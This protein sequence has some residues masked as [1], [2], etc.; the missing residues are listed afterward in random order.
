MRFLR[1]ITRSLILLLIALFSA[2]AAMRFAIHGREVRVPNLKGLSVLQAQEMANQAGLIVAVDDKFYS[3]YVPDGKIISQAP[4]ANS[5]VRRGW[6]VRVAE[7][8]GEQRVTIPDLLGQTERAATLNLRRRGLEVATVA[9]VP[10]TNASPDQVVA[11]VPLANAAEVSS[12]KVSI[13]LAEAP[14]SPEFVMPNFLGRQLADAKQKV[15]RAGLQIASVTAAATDPDASA[16]MLPV[17]SGLDTAR[18]SPKSGKIVSQS[19]APGA[20]VTPDTQIRFEIAQ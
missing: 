15:A 5:K 16:S 7:S 2:L 12:P 6:R 11:Q 20:R 18:A 17:P 19:P 4:A 13:L 8:L 3:S 1:W 10:I 9:G 14:K